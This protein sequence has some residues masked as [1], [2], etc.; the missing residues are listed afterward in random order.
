MVERREERLSEMLNAIQT[1][2]CTCT[3]IPF[4]PYSLRRI[5]EK[6]LSNLCRREDDEFSSLVLTTKI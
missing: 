2:I 1:H 4:E 3:M 5:S 6:W